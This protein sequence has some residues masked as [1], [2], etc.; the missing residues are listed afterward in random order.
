M[1]IE[2]GD[3]GENVKQVQRAL[4][5]LGFDVDD[6]GIFG[7]GTEAAVMEF[8][9]TQGLND[10]GIVGPATLAALG[11]DDASQSDTNGSPDGT[12]VVFDQDEVDVPE[13]V[14]RRIDEYVERLERQFDQVKDTSNAA[15]AN[16]ET[17]MKFASTDEADPDLL[18]S[19]VSR[20]FDFAVDE[21]ISS[22][23]GT[24][25]GLSLAKGVFEAVTDE[26]QRAS[27]ATAGA[28]IGE[29]IKGQRNGLARLSFDSEK[30]KEEIALEYLEAADK[31][32]YSDALFEASQLLG[33]DLFPGI[34]DLEVK[35]YEEWINAHFRGIDDDA[36]GCIEYRYEF[37]D[38]G[39]NFVSCTVQAVEGDK[40]ESAINLVFDEGQSS[41]KRPIDL[42][43]RKRA[44]FRTDNFVGG[45]SWFC[46]WLDE[47]NETI[48]V[49][50]M[51]V[52][53]QAFH[54][55]IWRH[56]KRFRQ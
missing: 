31:P 1:A 56:A 25:P 55:P 16:F 47:N 17:T 42:K 51:D 49:P 22:L 2:R 28:S 34:T 35:L 30:W 52:A 48:H 54:E 46:G 14:R 3:R 36:K 41:A 23:K 10:D 32:Q 33:P 7:A 15:L 5:E 9:R 50:I 29:W 6:D 21:V 19:V 44:C 45:K 18:G 43:V 13:N 8:Q 39:F 12:D 37:D 38:D 4:Q 11:L 27:R 20:V 40:L 24:V 26:L 53:E